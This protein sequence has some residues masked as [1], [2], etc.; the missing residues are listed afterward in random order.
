MTVDPL[1]G[2]QRP[3][4][5]RQQRVDGLVLGVDGL[6]GGSPDGLA[7][8]ADGGR[9]AAGEF[10]GEQRLVCFGWVPSLSL[11]SGVR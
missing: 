6:A 10:L 7:T 11:G 8:A 4:G 2:A 5:W 3:L 1:Q 9:L